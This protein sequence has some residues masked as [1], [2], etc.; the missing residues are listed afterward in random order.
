MTLL[1]AS[2][3]ICIVFVS[4]SLERALQIFPKA[5]IVSSPSA[6]LAPAADYVPVVLM[7]GLGD[8][9][10]N[11]GMQSLAQSISAAYPGL[12]SVA[13][14]VG[15]GI[16]SFIEHI[17]TQV[18]AFAAV[19]AADPKLARGFSAV[20]L[21][22]GGLI[23]R[24]YIEQYNNPPVRNFVSIC[25]VQNG[26][27]DCPLEI[28]IIPFLC[29][30][31]KADPYNFLFNGSF[32]ISFS[33]YWVSYDNETEY[34]TR[35][36]FL[37]KINN[38]VQHGNSSLYK[39]RLSSLDNLVLAEA[40]QDTVV[41]PY[42]SEQFGGYSWD[43]GDNKT[44]FTFTES[45]QYV[46]NLL[47]LKDLYDNNQISFLSFEGDHLRFNDSWWAEEIMPYFNVSF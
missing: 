4:A 21:S 41:Y 18:D 16:L 22:Q 11:A 3:L 31:F 39:Q 35:N 40:L 45:D 47:G 29:D 6:P 12:Y 13:V 14:D 20:G 33:D 43:S 23:V 2:L 5:P 27:Y 44:I 34:L 8:A 28:Q 25:G 9:G 46:D 19:V 42:Q 1:C 26:V 15:D 30:L 38:Q 17:Q 37:P 7:H 36:P 32:P 10:S 24:G